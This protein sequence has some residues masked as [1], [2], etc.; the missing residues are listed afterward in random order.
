VTLLGSALWALTILPRSLPSVTD[1]EKLEPLKG[2]KIYDENDD[3]V[4][5]LHVE[6]RIFV[7]LSQVPR[8]LQDAVIATEDRRF[9][10]HWGVDPIGIGRA[11]LQNYRPAASWRAGTI[12][13][14]PPSSLP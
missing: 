1:L 14:Q 8:S 7:P 5:E 10:Y 12:T 3:L 13:Q 2:T 4:T 11:V 9:Y 6:R